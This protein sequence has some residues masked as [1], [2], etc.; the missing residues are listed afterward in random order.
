MGNRWLRRAACF[1]AMA[2]LLL[3]GRGGKAITVISSGGKS[4]ESGRLAAAQSAIR[5]DKLGSYGMTPIRAGDIADGVYEVRVA[6]TSP[7]FKIVSAQLTVAGEGMTADI[8]LGSESYTHVYMGDMAGAE[9]ADRGDW[10]AG[11]ATEGNTVFTIPV[12]ALNMPFDCAAYSKARQRWYDR[13]LLI[14]AA[15]LPEGALEFELP[16]YALIQKAMLAYVESAV[17]SEGAAPEEVPAPEPAAVNL[18][19][20]EYSVEVNLAGG[21][22]RASV[23]SPTLMIVRDGKAWARLL[24]SSPYYDYMLIG[25]T[26]YENLTVDGGNSTFEIPITSMDA[27]MNVVAD[28]TAMGDP[29]EIDYALSFYGDTVADKG[30]IPQEAAK[31]VLVI[32]GAIIAVGAVLNHFVKKRRR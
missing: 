17:A 12:P 27:P 30:K 4:D 2:V 6:S 11:E 9:G 20:G 8:R 10:I 14:D 28:T 3:V 29:I 18:A 23:S 32:S 25:P 26:R 31:Q 21:S 1:A 19:D 7:F 13:Q 15:S 5:E 24:W 22:G 16:D